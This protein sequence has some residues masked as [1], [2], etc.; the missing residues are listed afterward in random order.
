MPIAQLDKSL[1]SEVT[2]GYGTITIRVVVLEKALAP[3]PAPG[4]AADLPEDMSPDEVLPDT[5]KHSELFTKNVERI[6]THVLWFG[7]RR[8]SLQK[9]DIPW[10]NEFTFA[11]IIKD[12]GDRVE[13]LRLPV[14]Y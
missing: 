10:R 3:A 14:S 12:S 8:V 6:E 1:S 13:V 7:Q 9:A 2:E 11:T 4:A 5:D